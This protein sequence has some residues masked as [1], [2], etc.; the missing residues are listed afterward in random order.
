MKKLL[1]LTFI[2]LAGISLA[3]G[4]IAHHK[5]HDP[6]GDFLIRTE[7]YLGDETLNKDDIQLY[8][9]QFNLDPGVLPEGDYMG[10]CTF[11][12]DGQRIIL[13]NRITN[14]VT[15]WDWNSMDVLSNIFVGEYPSCVAANNEFAVIGCQ[16]ADSVY[17]I[18]LSDYSIA[19]ILPTAEQPSG[20][21]LSPDGNTAY[22]ACDIDDVCMVI[23]LPTLNVSGQINDFP[24]YLQTFSW[25]AQVGRNWV[26]YN[27][28]VVLPDGNSIAISDPDGDVV[29]FSTQTYLETGRISIE[30]PRAVSLSGDG[31]YLLCA[32]NPNNTCTVHQIDLSDLS[33]KHT[34]EVSGNYLAT[35]AIVGN[36]DGS[37]AYI[38]TGNNTST[39]IRF[40]T[41]DFISFTNTYTAFWLGISH[42]HQYAVSGQNRFSIIDFDSETIVDQH[43]GLNQSFGTVSPVS[44]HVFGYDPL[45]FEGAYFFD[46]TDPSDIEYRGYRLSG[47][48]PEG[49]TPGSVAISPDG[50]KAVSINN[51]SYN[52][53]VINLETMET[54]AVIDLEEACYHV[55]I[56]PDGQW[57]VCGGYNL[58]T[59]K[60]LDLSDNSLATTV[61]TGQRP[62]VIELSPDGQYA[63]VGNIKQNTLSKVELDG[64][65]S[66]LVTSVPCGVI[67]VYMPFYGL[68]SAVIANPD[69]N[70]VLVAASFDDKVKVFDTQTNQIV[71][72]LS[73]GDFPLDIA[74]NED[75]N[76][77]CV[78]NVFDNTFNI[79]SIDGA[80][81]SV[82]YQ[83]SIN[84]QYPVDVSYNAEDGLFWIC[85]S[86]G[87]NI[88]KVDPFTGDL[89]E[90]IYYSGVP[91][92]TAF[93]PQGIA[94]IQIQ[95]SDNVEHKVLYGEHEFVLPGNAA[96]LSYTTSAAMLG[97]PIPGPDYLSMIDLSV[98]QGINE[99]AMNEDIFIYPVPA[100]E[101]L[102]M[103]SK[104]KYEFIEIINSE[105]KM[106]LKS[107]D[108]EE[109]GL[110]IS[111]LE[112]GLYILK[113]TGRNLSV[114]RR[115]VVR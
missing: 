30:S 85:T 11:T 22:V 95:G 3:Y 111:M 69:G 36:Q 58:N 86:G 50:T 32:S 9:D 75:G 7:S 110:D 53:S 27:G 114:S 48:D 33:I 55:K 35:N 19:A 43:L 107:D 93:D 12:P 37:K 56:T 31:N 63:Y 105:G 91:F 42:D 8:R 99:S 65:N 38:G 46:F 59:I 84:G 29:F 77:A 4:Q 44:N 92:H 88:N 71:A 24:I 68:R 79:L 49:D 39:L 21:Q 113:V 34:V 115:F 26:K 96:P 18:N 6:E 2:T 64:A 1:I 10:N 61:Y 98:Y 108:F 60:I 80:S 62:M 5:L 73:T 90:V 103:R 78:I 82:L 14:V 51:L 67:G 23:D 104:L 100:G 41:E 57:A 25:A 112:A 13:T 20:I 15:I 76:L 70:S 102:F 89:V 94:I 45:R 28:F 109:E 72:S 81:S 74:F 40:E 101:R 106:V 97:V 54:E 17:I 87:K 16:F 83:N 47:L 66:S 52:C